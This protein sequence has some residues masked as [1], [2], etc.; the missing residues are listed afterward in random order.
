[1]LLVEL[2]LSAVEVHTPDRAVNNVV[3]VLADGAGGVGAGQVPAVFCPP[4]R[5]ARLA[6]PTT[7]LFGLNN[8][9][10]D[11][12]A[13]MFPKPLTVPQK[14]E[15]YVMLKVDPGICSRTSVPAH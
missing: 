15:S 10:P 7:K 3:A 12:P 14:V 5:S 13:P 6:L 1:L 2:D 11:P 9:E 4:V 8:A